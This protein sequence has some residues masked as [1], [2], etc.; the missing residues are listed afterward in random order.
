MQVSAGEVHSHPA[1]AELPDRLQVEVLG[2]LAAGEQSAGAGFDAPGPLAAAQAGPLRE[3]AEGGRRDLVVPAAHRGLDEL[4]QDPDTEAELVMLT[5]LL[6]GSES[7]RVVTQ[8]VVEHGSRE[9]GAGHGQSLAPDGCLLDPGFELARVVATPASE[10]QREVGYPRVAGG[11]CDRVRLFEQGRSGGEL[12]RED[13]VGRDVVE[14]EREHGERPGFAGLLYVPGGQHAAGLV[15]P[16]VHGRVAAEP[17]PARVATPGTTLAVAEGAQCTLECG[18]ACRVTLCGPGRQ[19]VEEEVHG[20]RW[21]GWRWRGPGGLG[22][23]TWAVAAAGPAGADRRPQRFQVGLA[24]QGGVER[25]EAPGRLEQQ[26]GSVAA[27]QPGEGDLRVQPFQPGAFQFAQRSCPGDGQLPYGRVGHPRLVLGLRCGQRAGGARPRRWRQCSGAF[28]E[29]SGRGQ[30]PAGVRAA[31]R[32]LQLGSDALI[33]LKR[34][35]G[36]VP[37]PPVGIGTRIGGLGD[38]VVGPPAVARPAPPGRR[39]NGPAGGGR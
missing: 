14:G 12:A 23:V 39:R 31:R 10:Q 7:G 9:F 24:G 25:A 18:Y 1:V 34:G 11:G 20:P 16:Q 26:R 27:P 13:V 19:A 29:G 17:Q 33:G 37:G 4:G 2:V 21:A 22:H 36:P 3:L 5:G 28:E 8:P 30:A 38:G 6:C 35:L 15:I 32:A